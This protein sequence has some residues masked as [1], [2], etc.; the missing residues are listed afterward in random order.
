MNDEKALDTVTRE[1]LSMNHG[2]APGDPPII[3][4]P[5]QGEKGVCPSS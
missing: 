4:I 1:L 5:H 2:H 3:T